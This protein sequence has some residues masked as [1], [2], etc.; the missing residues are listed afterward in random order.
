MKIAI[1]GVW[2]VHA[3]DYTKKALEKLYESRDNNTINK[4]D[5]IKNGIDILNIVFKKR[6]E[7]DIEM[8]SYEISRLEYIPDDEMKN[9]VD[10]FYGLCLTKKVLAEGGVGYARQILEKAFGPQM[11][12][13][14]ME[15]VNKTLERGGLTS[16]LP[17]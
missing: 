7:D 17:P 4:E 9:I 2:H 13:S 15:R 11:A 6:D 1:F 8:L 3:K 14:Y 5:F 10:D 16:W 12:V